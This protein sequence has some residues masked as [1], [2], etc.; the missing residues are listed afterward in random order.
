MTHSRFGLEADCLV[1]LSEMF[2]P[3]GMAKLDE[4]Q[5]AVLQH[6]R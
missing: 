6:R 4:V 1:R 2:A 5:A 3:L